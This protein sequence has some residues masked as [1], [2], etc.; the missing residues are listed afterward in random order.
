VATAY[1]Q[2][3]CDLD[4][5]HA[6]CNEAENLLNVSVLEFRPRALFTS[7]VA[8]GVCRMAVSITDRGAP[9]DDHVEQVGL[10][11]SEPQMAA[12]FVQDAV[13]FVRP[14][15]IVP[16]ARRRIARMADDATAWDG[17]SGG[18]FPRATMSE[19]RFSVSGESPVPPGQR[20]AGPDEAFTV[21]DQRV[22]QDFFVGTTVC[23]PARH[24]AQEGF[25][26]VDGAG[27]SEEAT[28]AM[29]T[30]TRDGTLRLHQGYLLVSAPRWLPPRGGTSRCNFTMSDQIEAA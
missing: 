18:T 12:P 30:D 14:D 19:Y 8:I 21:S 9:F 11:G 3:F 16:D 27:R 10:L 13:D 23:Q 28:A 20:L 6:D 25:A 29:T 15:I 17:P 5:T 4:I 22:P 26:G 1:G 2:P 7:D 24:A